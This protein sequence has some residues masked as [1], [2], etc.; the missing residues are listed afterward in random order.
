MTFRTI[1]ASTTVALVLVA[2]GGSTTNGEGGGLAGAGGQAGGGGNAGHAGSAGSAG[3]GGGP[4]CTSDGDC[5]T[6]A[7]CAVCADGSSTSCATGK[8]FEGACQVIYP[9]CPGVD[10]GS[11]CPAAVPMGGT[12]SGNLHCE[13]G[14]ET[15]C[16]HT[17]PSTVCDCTGGTFACFATDACMMPPDACPD[18]GPPPPPEVVCGGL[19]GKPC[20]GQ[21]ECV[22]P[23]T[24]ADCFGHCECNVTLDCPNGWFQ[25]TPDVC[26]CVAGG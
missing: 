20:P 6:P 25:P 18:G 17:F 16:G 9:P 7:V 12:C 26:A 4:A 19:V 2:C 5:V 21:G 22:V 8:C 15:C 13:Y 24:C 11:S 14:T 1:F 10:G 23:D 3:S